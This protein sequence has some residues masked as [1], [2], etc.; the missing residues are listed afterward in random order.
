MKSDQHIAYANTLDE[1]L[2]T[3]DAAIFLN[4]SK[5]FQDLTN[6]QFVEYMRNPVVFDFKGVLNPYV[7]K[8]VEYYAIGKKSYKKKE[9]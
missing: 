3:C 2:K 6:E 7:L 1:A 4:Q 5:E 9:N 8:D